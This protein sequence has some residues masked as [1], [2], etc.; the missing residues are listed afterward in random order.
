MSTLTT[1]M[2]QCP[3]AKLKQQSNDTKIKKVLDATFTYFTLNK[4]FYDEKKF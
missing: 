4:N 2:K 3:L 1:Y